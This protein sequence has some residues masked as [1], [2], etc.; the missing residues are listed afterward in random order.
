MSGTNNISDNQPTILIHHAYDGF[1][2]APFFLAEELKYFPEK[3]KLEFSGTDEEAINKLSRES[4][5]EAKHWFAICDPLIEKSVA[6][7]RGEKICLVGAPINTAPIWLFSKNSDVKPIN[8]EEDIKKYSPYVKKI[9]TYPRGTTGYLFGERI[10]KAYLPDAAIHQSA[11]GHEFDGLSDDTLV[12]TSDIFTM[13]HEERSK[14]GK[15][16]FCYPDHGSAETENF[17]FTGI[18]TLRHAVLENN[19]DIVIRVLRDVKKSID[20]L[21]SDDIQKRQHV[22]ALLAENTHFCKKLN[23]LGYTNQ[24]SRK[25]FMMHVMHEAKRW[26]LYQNNLKPDKKA[27]INAQNEWR[28]LYRTKDNWDKWHEYVQELPSILLTSDWLSR[29][30]EI[31]KAT[32]PLSKQ[33]ITIVQ[34]FAFIILLCSMP[35][36]ISKQ[37]LST[38]IDVFS[39]EKFKIG[40]ET[41]KKLFNL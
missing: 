32:L 5:I 40:F 29:S 21:N 16:V 27:F 22:A 2:Y 34:I 1:L 36:V 28:K 26:N 35:V 19:F 3:V 17:L 18:L 37:S 9:M 30:D 31:I 12:V 38:F 33:K 24:E 7:G 8:K 10:K 4:T 20:M 14:N 41:I 6:S 39:S 15:I 25:T 11:F 13:V 23:K